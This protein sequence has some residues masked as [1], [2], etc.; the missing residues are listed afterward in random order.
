MFQASVHRNFGQLEGS[1]DQGVGKGK[2]DRGLSKVAVG[3]Y[4]KRI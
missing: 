3:I 2:G 1:G 4:E